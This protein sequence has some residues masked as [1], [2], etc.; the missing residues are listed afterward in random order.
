[1][2]HFDSVVALS[3]ISCQTA[4]GGGGDLAAV[5]RPFGDAH[6]ADWPKPQPV[7]PVGIERPD[8]NGLISKQSSDK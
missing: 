6:I 3:P 2:S 1:V 4:E 5:E 7:A 8:R